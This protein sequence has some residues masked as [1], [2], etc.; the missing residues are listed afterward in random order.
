M[1]TSNELGNPQSLKQKGQRLG[2]IEIPGRRA[3]QPTSIRD[4]TN[5]IWTNSKPRKNL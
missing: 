4:L 1:N 3:I 5:S 2:G